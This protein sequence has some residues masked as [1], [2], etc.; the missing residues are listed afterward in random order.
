[1]ACGMYHRRFEGVVGLYW[2]PVNLFLSCLLMTYLV[3]IIRALWHSSW[4]RVGQLPPL[5]ITLCMLPIIRCYG[6]D[7]RQNVNSNPFI[8][9]SYSAVKSKQLI[10]SF[11]LSITGERFPATGSTA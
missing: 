3:Q 10:S 8:A 1:M 4:D 9:S 11:Y 5:R 2:W 7:A 6:N